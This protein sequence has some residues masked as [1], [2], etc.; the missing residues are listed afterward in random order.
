MGDIDDDGLPISE[1]GEWA[2]EKHARL[3]KYIRTYRHVREK[4]IDPNKSKRRASV[5]KVAGATYVELFCGPGKCRV[6]ETGQ[7]IDGSPLVA[8]KTALA[9][10]VPF[11]EIHLADVNP[12]FSAAAVA[13]VNANGG[14]A[15]GYV[16]TAEVTARKIVSKLNPE[17]LHFAFIDP[18]NLSGLSFALIRTLSTLQHVDLLLH[19]SVLDLQR[20]S[21]RYTAQ[22]YDTFETFAP[23]WR[24]K[25]MLDQ[26]LPA[27]RGA[28][29]AHW[30]D[31]VK[32]LGFLD[33]RSAE[34]IRGSRNQRL[35]W[36]AFASRHPIANYFWN[37]I[38]STSGQRKWDF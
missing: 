10:G 9:D 14:Q 28:V 4:F 34:L 35:Y 2:V 24:S 1:V 25:V 29:L 19:V 33:I 15:V 17:G 16:G 23:G 12:D 6:R 26:G 38:S 8:C 22:E 31:L 11:S 36:L 3:E 32:S 20:N 21:D 37:Q 30:Q 27:I 13:R 7:L 5:G 18:W